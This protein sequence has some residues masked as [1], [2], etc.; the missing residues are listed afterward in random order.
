MCA[1]DDLEKGG[2]DAEDSNLTQ[3]NLQKLNK[4][5]LGRSGALT[6]DKLKSIMS[7]LDEVQVS[8]RLSEIDAVRLCP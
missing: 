2:A 3:E 8:D 1:V 6:S 5:G 7:F 4:D